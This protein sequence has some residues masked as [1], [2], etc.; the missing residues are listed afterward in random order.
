M[1]GRAE[2][3]AGIQIKKMALEKGK[4]ETEAKMA[5]EEAMAVAVEEAMAVAV[6]EAKMTTV[7]IDNLVKHGLLI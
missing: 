4:K 7:S 3:T 2:A 5:V 1:E 6:E